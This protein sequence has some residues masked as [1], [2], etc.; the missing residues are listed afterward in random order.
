MSETTKTCA[1]DLS[2]A[3]EIAGF[4]LSLGAVTGALMWPTTM[5]HLVETLRK[6]DRG[7]IAMLRDLLTKALRDSG[8]ETESVSDRDARYMVAACIKACGGTLEVKRSDLVALHPRDTIERY[9]DP[10][11][12]VTRLT[13]KAARP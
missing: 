4:Y 7:Y 2:S 10:S 12:D 13:Y 1:Y 5:D 3:D 8:V 6:E 9:D 11:G